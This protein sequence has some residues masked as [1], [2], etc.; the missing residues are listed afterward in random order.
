MWIGNIRK[1]E[2]ILKFLE[3][4]Y[5]IFEIFV[6]SPVLLENCVLK[7]SKKS[8][9]MVVVFCIIFNM[10]SNFTACSILNAI[11]GLNSLLLRLAAQ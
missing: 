3:K 2:K 5:N 9:A 6:N 4:N 1:N 11:L 7:M 10:N 8:V